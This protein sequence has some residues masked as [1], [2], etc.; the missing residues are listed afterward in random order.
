[1]RQIREEAGRPYKRNDLIFQKKKQ[2]KSLMKHTVMKGA[3]MGVDSSLALPA[4]Q[5]S[6]LNCFDYSANT[7]RFVQMASKAIFNL[8]LGCNAYRHL[9][10]INILSKPEYSS[11]S[12]KQK[13]E[14]AMKM[15]HSFLTQQ[16]YNRVENNDIDIDEFIRN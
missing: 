8:E 1:M 2:N 11:L 15:G 14:I 5:G 16:I 10:V 13:E 9:A 12:Q 3:E 4:T 7:N 6:V